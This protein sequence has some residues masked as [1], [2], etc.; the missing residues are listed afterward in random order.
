MLVPLKQGFMSLFVG[1]LLGTG[2]TTLRLNPPNYHLQG[3]GFTI[4]LTAE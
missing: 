2:R 4:Q 1:Y 3:E